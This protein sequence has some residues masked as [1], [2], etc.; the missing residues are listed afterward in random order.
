MGRCGTGGAGRDGVGRG[1]TEWGGA[2]RASGRSP[3]SSMPRLF[4]MNSALVIFCFTMGLWASVLSMI[5]L[6]GVGPPGVRALG[7]R[8]QG[9]GRG[10]E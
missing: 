6:D 1:G 7:F 5:T 2:G 4:L 10:S 3:P 9:S 8:V